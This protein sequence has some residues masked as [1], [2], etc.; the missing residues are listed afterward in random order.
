M[1]IVCVFLITLAESLWYQSSAA[2]FACSGQ[3]PQH[4]SVIRVI[5]SYSEDS[6]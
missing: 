1:R 2:G 6:L 5:P 4:Y 3:N